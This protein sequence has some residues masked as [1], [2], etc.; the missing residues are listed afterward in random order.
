MV[1]T[2]SAPRATISISWTDR[3]PVSLDAIGGQPLSRAGVS[4]VQL[5]TSTAQRGRTSQANVRTEI[6]DRLRYVS[7]DESNT[8]DCSTTVIVQRDDVTQLVVETTIEMPA[9]GSVVRVASLVRNDSS[10]RIVL[11]SVGSAT[12]GLGDSESDLDQM[13]LAYAESEWI[14]ENRWRD[15]PL[16][17]ALPELG[18]PLHAQDGRGHFA[19]SSHGSW[20]TGEKLPLGII[21]DESSG[22]SVA[23]QIESSAQ[24]TWDLTQTLNGAVLSLMGPTDLE[25]QFAHALAPGESFQTV[26]AA[27]ATS[28]NGRDG[29]IGELTA[30]RRWLRRDLPL[31]PLPVIYNDFMNTLMGQPTSEALHPLIDAAA[32]AGVDLFCIDAGW[33]APPSAADWWPSVG[34]WRVDESRFTGGFQSVTNHIRERGMRLGMWLEPEVVGVDSPIAASLP[35]EAFFTRFGARVVED[36]RFHLDLRHPAARA[37]LDATVDHLV[38]EYGV[39]YLKL[40]YNINPG[41]GTEVNATAAG[42]GLLAHARALQDWVRDLGIRHSGL[43]VENCS[44]GAMRADYGLLSIAHLQST[45]DQQNFTLYPPIAASAPASILPEQCG[46]WAYP[47]LG[48]SHEDA[49]FTLVTGLSGRLY[50][51][52]FLNLLEADTNAL[53]HEAV[54]IHKTMREDLREAVPFWPLGLPGWDDEVVCLGLRTPS[55]EY[56]FVWDR[57]DR[58]RVIE[59]TGLNSPMRQVFPQGDTAWSLSQSVNITRIHTATGRGARVYVVDAG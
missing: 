22:A 43:L 53:V 14:A 6:G 20:S 31:E 15:V 29:A 44:S 57:A 25:H 32:D 10:S 1:I 36:R 11:T 24:W 4:L 18:L 56:L 16:R 40:D 30:Y 34:E 37:H 7:H 13:R 33:F 3:R 21:V 9:G 17:E 35:D 41:A 45:S 47:A 2:T 19:L 54:V 50:L 55:T 59:L 23:W 8:E 12:L 38:V 58:A 39:S 49:I 52:G 46:N 51:S 5:T 27:I 26:P 28:P 48:M 42:D